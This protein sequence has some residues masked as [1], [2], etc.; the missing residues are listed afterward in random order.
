MSTSGDLWLAGLQMVL[1]EPQYEGG[2]LK[3]NQWKTVLEFGIR[4]SA[5]RR[6]SMGR[7][8]RI[9][10]VLTMVMFLAIDTSIAGCLVRRW[11]ANYYWSQPSYAG[12]CPPDPCGTVYMNS[13]SGVVSYPI[14]DQSCCSPGVVHQ[15]VPV[16]AR[17]AETIPGTPSRTERPITPE[18]TPSDAPDTDLPPES[19]ALDEPQAEVEE[20]PPATVPDNGFGELESDRP[21]DDGDLDALLEPSTETPSTT[22][23]TTPDATTPSADTAPPSTDTPADTPAETPP[24][25]ESDPLGD[26]FDDSSTS[27]EQ[28]ADD[29]ARVANNPEETDQEGEAP[30][31]GSAPGD[32]LNSNEKA[33]ELEDLFDDSSSVQPRSGESTP[34]VASPKPA[35][36][37]T[38]V[39]AVAQQKELPIRRWID[40]TG[41]YSAIGRLVSVSETHVRLLKINGRYSTVPKNRL[42]Q[43]DLRYVDRASH[44]LDQDSSQVIALR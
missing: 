5:M 19:D 2:S 28:P 17:P 35:N 8:F 25:E 14:V 16:E 12:W 20:T 29:G 39:P 18:P 40:N 23:E 37:S 34:A 3:R 44:E 21:T 22:P 30:A 36:E 7:V 38:T 31:D 32:L 6:L 24:A 1:C 27:T 43:N 15:G 13:C 11:R 42:S 33:G 10:L 41:S 4:T 26:L 9:G